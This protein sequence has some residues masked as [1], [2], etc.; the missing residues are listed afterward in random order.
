M[1]NAKGGEPLDFKER[2][3]SEEM[4]KEQKEQHRH[5]GMPFDGKIASARDIGN[6]AAG[7]VAGVHGI[8]WE[9]A[10]LAFDALETMQKVGFWQT[11]RHYPNNRII[12][13]QPT[14]QAQYKGYTQGQYT[15]ISRKRK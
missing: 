12:E 10:R 7:Y 9:S 14:Q 5:R 4:S 8:S 6:Y 1:S 3:V 15:Y 11:V 2:V 13:G